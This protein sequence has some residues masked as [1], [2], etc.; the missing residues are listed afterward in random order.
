MDIFR[1]IAAAVEDRWRDQHHDE[2]ALPAIA[3]AELLDRLPKSGL[4]PRDVIEWVWS[5]RELPRQDDL[6]AEFGQPPVTV[7]RGSRFS[8]MV[9]YWLD[10]TTS[11]HQHSFSGAF[12][13]LAGSS[14]HSRYRFKPE[15]RLNS[16]LFMGSVT[17]DSVEL[18][19][20]GDARPILSGTDFAHA[21]FHLDH[22]SV[23]VV[24]RTH[25]DPGS[26]PQLQYH[27]PYLARDPFYK[28]PHTTR[29]VQFL[30]MLR[31]SSSLDYRAFLERAVSGPDFHQALTVLLEVFEDEATDWRSFRELFAVCRARHGE[32]AD[33]LEA[34]FLEYRREVRIIRLRRTISDPM[35]RF[36][37]ALLINVPTRAE[38]LALTRKMCPDSDPVETIVRWTAELTGINTDGPSGPNLLGVKLDEVSLEVL[39]L[40]LLGCSDEKAIERLGE[41]Y[42][43]DDIREQR[44]DLLELCRA[45]R[46]SDYFKPL[47]V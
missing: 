41:Q 43:E 2:A 38:I 25:R 1:E 36:F 23:S 45:L 19:N 8:I 5:A 33:L 18:L 30:T 29:I 35:H 20:Q 32:L 24:L 13:V 46:G 4:T 12:Y 28:H 7:Y 37:L 44:A 27:R 26:D 21:L 10:A 31:K 22:P 3:A 17:L 6:L 34:T 39:R 47:F 15:R 11:I 14:I 40:L 16:R 9:L 42:D